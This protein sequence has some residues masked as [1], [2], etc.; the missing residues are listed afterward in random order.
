MRANSR[1]W[2]RSSTAR[3]PD[4][5]APLSQNL[6]AL[7]VANNNL[8]ASQLQPLLQAL[9]LKKGFRKLD[10]SGN[11]PALS[12]P[13]IATHIAELLKINETIAEIGV[14]G[15]TELGLC[16]FSI[17]F[18]AL[19]MRRRTPV[20]DQCLPHPQACQQTSPTT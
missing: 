11:N 14:D 19:L 12:Q 1:R 3:S 5:N 8:S 15:I 18:H 9:R 6:E 2:S 10:L 17:S 7:A 16:A 13:E 4:C 20:A